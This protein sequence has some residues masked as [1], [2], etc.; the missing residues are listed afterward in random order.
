[1][2]APPRER[3]PGALTS[4][5][6]SDREQAL[7]RLLQPAKRDSGPIPPEDPTAGHAEMRACGEYEVRGRR[8]LEDVRFGVS[9]RLRAAHRTAILLLPARRSAGW[10]RT[11]A[12]AFR[13]LRPRRSLVRGAR[14][15]VGR[16]Y[17]AVAHGVRHRPAH[18]IGRG[19]GRS[20]RLITRHRSRACRRASGGDPGTVLHAGA[21][22]RS[23]IGCPLARHHGDRLRP[24]LAWP[25]N[26]PAGIRSAGGV[27]SRCR[28]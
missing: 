2:A 25:S 17:R 20:G 14:V 13:L 9:M 6:V 3:Q 12:L 23:G 4:R 16:R 11:R 27:T 10:H 15:G 28:L 5:C 18:R 1:M 24:R 19:R 7:R 8:T 26:F 22:G 21:G